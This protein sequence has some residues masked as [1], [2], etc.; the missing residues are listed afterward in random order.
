NW[1]F[2]GYGVPRVCA[3]HGEPAVGVKTLF[4][5]RTPGWAYALLALGVL[6]FLIAVHATRK[7]MLAPSWPFCAR[8]KALRTRNLVLGWSGIAVGIALSCAMGAVAN[9]D[10][11]GL[12]GARAARFPTSTACPHRPTTAFQMRAEPFMASHPLVN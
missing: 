9:A 1:V 2:A 3:R 6:P 5:S 12:E 11:E 7:S 4:R 10:F 8:C